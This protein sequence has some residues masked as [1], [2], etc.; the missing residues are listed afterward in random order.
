MDALCNDSPYLTTVI[1]QPYSLFSGSTYYRPLNR[2]SIVA[3]FL[4]PL[5]NPS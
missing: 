5:L 3:G 4:I 2:L 1:P